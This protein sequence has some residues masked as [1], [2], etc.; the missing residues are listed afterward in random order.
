[1]KHNYHTMEWEEF[2]EYLT[3]KLSS[4][5]PPEE[6]TIHTQFKEALTVLTRCISETVEAKVPKSNPSS[7][8]KC[9]W[10]KEL[11]VECKVVRKLARDSRKHLA[12]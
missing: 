5:P 2:R 4:I 8:V 11:E 12:R 1:P 9:Q 6:L 3:N 10:S 7:Y